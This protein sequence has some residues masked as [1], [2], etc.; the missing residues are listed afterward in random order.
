MGVGRAFTRL[1]AF[2]AA[3]GGVIFFWRKRQAK[4]T[5]PATSPTASD[6]P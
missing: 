3:V 2:G 1:A 6:R 5:G 4:D